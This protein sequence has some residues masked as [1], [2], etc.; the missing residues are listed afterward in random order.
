MTNGGWT[1]VMRRSLDSQYEVDFQVELKSYKKGFGVL[2]AD[3]FL[4]L[5]NINLLTEVKPRQLMAIVNQTEYRLANF[6]VL[7]EYYHYKVIIEDEIDKFIDGS[8]FLRLNNSLFST[9]DVDYDLAA[10][11][12]CSSGWNAGWWFTDCFDHSVCMNCLIMHGNKGVKKLKYAVMLI[13]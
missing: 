8:S 1:V 10:N 2:N 7:N 13:K 9:I 3:H 6:K 11:S 12:N 5:D 4:G